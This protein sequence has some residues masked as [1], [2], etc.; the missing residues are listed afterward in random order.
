[1][2][3]KRVHTCVVDYY[4]LQHSTYICCFWHSAIVLSQRLRR[5]N[6]R[7]I[8]KC[9]CIRQNHKVPSEYILYF[10]VINIYI[11]IKYIPQA[12][13]SDKPGH[14]ELWKEYVPSSLCCI[15]I[16]STHGT[17]PFD[18]PNDWIYHFRSPGTYNTRTKTMCAYIQIYITNHK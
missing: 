13:M 12:I 1:M 7:K 14:F 15:Y 6:D 10:I 2:K 17:Y 11:N 18:R 5:W 3:S 8:R 9:L 16:F 4:I